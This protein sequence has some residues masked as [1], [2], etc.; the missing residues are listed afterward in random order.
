MGICKE[1]FIAFDVLLM[2]AANGTKAWF[3]NP[4]ITEHNQAINLIV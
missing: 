3:Q 4:N 1:P 2:L